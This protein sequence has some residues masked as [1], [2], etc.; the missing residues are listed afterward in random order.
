MSPAGARPTLAWGR[1]YGVRGLIGRDS[2][3]R[4]TLTAIGRS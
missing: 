4:Y 3:E 2:G 1:G